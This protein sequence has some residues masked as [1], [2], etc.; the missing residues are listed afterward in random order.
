MRVLTGSLFGGFLLFA[1]FLLLGTVDARAQSTPGKIVSL[2]PAFAALVDPAAKL[3]VLATGFQWTEGPVWVRDSGY[4]LFSD[5]KQNTIFKW[6]EGEGISVFLQPSGYTGRLPYSVEPGSNGL[7]I[8]RAGELVSCEHGDRRIAAMP[9][10]RGGKRTLADNWQGKRFNSPNDIVQAPNGDYY[11][12]D[13]AYGLPRG[14]KS[15]PMGLYRLSAAGQLSLIDEYAAPNGV[16]LSPDGKILYLAQ[17]DGA[18][19]YIMAYPVNSDGTAGK[20]KLF[21]DAGE[22]AKSGLQGAPDGLKTDQAGNVFSSGPGGII[23]LSPKGK[24]LGRIETGQP[25]SNCAWGDDGYLYITANMQLCRIKTR[26]K[27]F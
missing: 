6:K 3:E 5:V 26:T 25:T 10:S 2:D 19:P 24:L 22:L 14:E 20:A 4:L 8:N 18:K 11:F 13:P 16:A 17:S 12:T 27:G 9:L 15:I 23:V 1:A 7:T 21:Y